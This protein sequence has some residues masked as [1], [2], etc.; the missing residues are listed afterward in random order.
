[1]KKIMNSEEFENIFLNVFDNHAPLKRKVVRANHMPYMTNQHR[2]AIMRRSASEKRYYK[3]KSLEDKQ[4]FKKQRNYCNRL[5]KRGKGI[6]SITSI[7]RK[8]QS[9]KNSGNM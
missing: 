2:K 5:Y 9:T 1:M 8:L 4:A 7:W 3:S 6:T